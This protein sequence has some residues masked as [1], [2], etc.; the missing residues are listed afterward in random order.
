MLI[1]KIF[2][3]AEWD[4]FRQTGRSAGAPVDLADGFIH[5]STAEQV[6]GTAEKHFAGESD[7]VLVAVDAARLGD[8]LKWEPSR[9]GALFPHLYRDLRMADVVWD[10]SLPLGATGHIFPEGVV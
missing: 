7:L 6:T 1:Y 2:R 8:A 5:L 4:A 10:K 9:G 3:R